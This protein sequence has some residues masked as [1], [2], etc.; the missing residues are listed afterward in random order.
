M[1]SDL[2][3]LITKHSPRS[4]FLKLHLFK[5]NYC[6]SVY[7]QKLFKCKN[8]FHC[9]RIP[10]IDLFWA[11]DLHIS[12]SSEICC[13]A[14]SA[15]HV[16]WWH[17]HCLT[18]AAI[19]TKHLHSQVGMI[20]KL[21]WSICKLWTGSHSESVKLQTYQYVSCLQPGNLGFGEGKVTNAW[22]CNICQWPFATNWSAIDQIMMA[23][24]LRSPILLFLHDPWSICHSNS[25]PTIQPS[26]LSL[27]CY[28]KNQLA[29]S[30]G[31][32]QQPDGNH[33]WPQ[34][35]H[36]IPE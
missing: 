17:V 6:H 23:H 8:L 3:K 5:E 30:L 1:R 34:C 27:P 10:D 2:P 11:T 31:Y 12:V 36:G 35:S 9:N 25:V 18:N 29:R 7:H 32:L 15:L 28:S 16:L 14:L 22:N 33:G 4:Y 24:H 26:C 13:L 19:D 21:N 20:I